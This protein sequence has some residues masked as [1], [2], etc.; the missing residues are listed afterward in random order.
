MIRYHEE[1]E[2]GEASP[3]DSVFDAW[4]SAC[5]ISRELGNALTRDLYDAYMLVRD[6]DAFTFCRALW[7]TTG[8]KVG[9]SSG[10]VLAACAR[11]LYDHPELTNVVCIVA[12]S[13]DNYTNSIFDD[14]WV[15]R[16]G[17][18]L[19]VEYLGPVQDILR[20][21]TFFYQRGHLEQA[22]AGNGKISS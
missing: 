6:E 12:D 8:M 16:Q 4:R 17:L 10:A 14:E 7:D 15:R 5:L 11:Y 2:E 9:G 20:T 13:G 19:S 18:D 22:S 1:G 21:L 3:D